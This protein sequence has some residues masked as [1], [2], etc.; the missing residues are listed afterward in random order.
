[1]FVNERLALVLGEGRSIK[2]FY[3]KNMPLFEYKPKLK[4]AVD[5]E[6]DGSGEMS[7]FA[8]TEAT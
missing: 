8:R 7:G 5:G 4:K 1:M 6:G 3:L 2:Q